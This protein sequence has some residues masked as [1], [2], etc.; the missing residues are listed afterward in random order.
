MT[1][2]TRGQR[3][4]SCPS[5][6]THLPSLGSEPVSAANICRAAPSSRRPGQALGCALGELM[7]HLL[8]SWRLGTELGGQRG[9]GTL[10]RAQ[11]AS[12][13]TPLPSQSL[14]QQE[15]GALAEPFVLAWDAHSR[16][17]SCTPLVPERREPG[18]CSAGLLKP[19]L[20]GFHS[21]F[22]AAR[23]WELA[24][25]RVEGEQL[26]PHLERKRLGQGLWGSNQ[27]RLLP[28]RYSCGKHQQPGTRGVRGSRGGTWRGLTYCSSYKTSPEESG[29]PPCRTVLGPCMYVYMCRAFHVTSEFPVH[30]SVFMH[31]HAIWAV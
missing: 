18:P 6:P 8:N 23:P 22:P 4:P 9:R 11:E 20:I 1:S 13:T 26:I 7:L 5:T 2:H 10:A 15:R 16:P 27:S 3:I 19:R 21:L 14:P 28:P 30:T 29:F 25:R 31:V 17:A 12:C 24:A